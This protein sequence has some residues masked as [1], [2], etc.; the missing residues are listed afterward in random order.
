M[1]AADADA[2]GQRAAWAAAD[3][4][5]AEGRSARVMTPDVAGLDFNDIVQRQKAR[6]ASHG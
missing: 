6:E 3:A 5:M 2:P 4:F 1:I